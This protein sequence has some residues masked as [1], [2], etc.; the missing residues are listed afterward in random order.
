MD[1]SA[2]MKDDEMHKILIEILSITRVSKNKITVI[3]CDNEIRKVYKL[4]TEQDIQK[5]SSNNGSTAFSPVFQYIRDHNM[6]NC[7]LVY[8]TDGVGEKELTLK[9]F[10]KKTLW[11]ICGD[12]E[13]SLEKPYGEIKR[14]SREKYEKVEG[15]IG[16]KMVNEVIHDWAR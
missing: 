16:L 1:I 9:P 13:L 4:K 6:K 5:R 7:I 3:E 8:F 2:S 11:V 15:N 10:N 14:I 12:D